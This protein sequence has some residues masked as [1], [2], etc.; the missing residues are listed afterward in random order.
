MS[1][2]VSAELRRLVVGRADGIC[3][4]CLIHEADTWLGCQID[5]IISEKHGGRTD[6]DNLAYACVFCNRS[7]GADLGSVA[8]SSGDFVRFFNPRSDKW[9]D[10]FRLQRE[11][12]EPLTEIG[13]VTV[14]ILDLNSVERLLERESLLATGRF[15]SPEAAARLR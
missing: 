11:R 9:T 8:H 10:H 13:E 1:S 4:Y 15:P 6:A 3:E 2:Y 12:I 5:H 14:Q 7:K